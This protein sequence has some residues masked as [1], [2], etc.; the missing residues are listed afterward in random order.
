M[1]ME[2]PRRAGRLRTTLCMSAERAWTT[3]RQW[4]SA[5]ALRRRL[6]PLIGVAVLGLVLAT[7]GGDAPKVPAPAPT[8]PASSP[9][10]QPEP[11]SP[12]GV[13]PLTVTK[14]SIQPPDFPDAGFQIDE[15]VHFT[16]W[17]G[18]GN[19]ELRGTA[20]L[21]V[22]IGD[23]VR[24]IEVGDV[25][26]RD[27]LGWLYFRYV[28][29]AEDRDEDG[30][31][32]A[33]DALKLAEDSTLVD[34]STR[35]PVSTD[36]GDHALENASDYKVRALELARVTGIR[37]DEVGTD[38]IQ[39]V[40]DPVDNATE[41]EAVPHLRDTDP[42]DRTTYRVSEP[43]L[44]VDGFEPGSLVFISVR[45][46]V[47]GRAGPWSDRV[48]TQTDSR[49]GPFSRAECREKRAQ[50]EAWGGAIPEEWTGEPF[51]FYFDR[52]FLP[53]DEVEKAAQVIET[54][55]RMSRHIE[56]QLGYSV[57][58]I[59]GWIDLPT[60]ATHACGSRYNAWRRS[61]TMVAI[62]TSETHPRGCPSLPDPCASAGTAC[63]VVRYWEN[64][65]HNQRDGT[66]VHEIF[67]L[68][69][70][71]HS[72]LPLSNGSPH[73]W[74]SPPGKGIPM[75]VKL[76]SSRHAHPSD[77]SLAFEDVEALRCIYPE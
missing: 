42:D 28:I 26:N 68:L 6:A 57:V 56:D 18:G 19:I 23:D 50:V 51:V 48:T 71:T 30:L 53:E 39:W 45:A 74:Q 38:F 20:A 75:S 41:Y 31:S 8:A 3:L 35:L 22:V 29:T 2:A 11:S 66:I 21:S 44:R 12:A 43:V 60:D 76:T 27:G 10:S 40:W 25:G 46:V 17:W 37:I 64:R 72:R 13:A 77:L 16:I 36:L 15:N 58:E 54:A 9:P 47:A 61:G 70:F 62:V 1:L 7:C 34:V 14:V 67:H 24:T 52:T 73:S 33:R 5:D 65:V 49:S 69:G 63:G 55:E 32:V 59:G 4:M